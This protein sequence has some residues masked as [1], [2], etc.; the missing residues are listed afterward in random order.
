MV[1]DEALWGRLLNVQKTEGFSSLEEVVLMLMDLSFPSNDDGDE[2]EEDEESSSEAAQQGNAKKK[3][4][5]VSRVQ[6]L[7][8]EDL[9]G[10]DTTLE[11]L[12]GLKKAPREFLIEKLEDK[13][14]F[15]LLF[16]FVCV[17]PSA[18]V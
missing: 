10:N 5:N 6:L 1:K 14:F 3:K 16:F 8:F 9:K 18:M 2:E 13:V 17:S 11:Y 15:F 12:T 7:F 4:N